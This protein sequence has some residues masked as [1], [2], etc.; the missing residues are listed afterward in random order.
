MFDHLMEEVRA[1]NEAYGWV[2]CLE[3]IQ[4]I[5]TNRDEYRGTVVYLELMKFM[6][7]GARLFATAE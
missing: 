5:H 7:Q 6:Q 4:F 1:I 3:A 2:G